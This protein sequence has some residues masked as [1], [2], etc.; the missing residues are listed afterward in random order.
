[1]S[2]IENRTENLSPNNVLLE[3]GGGVLEIIKKG[4]IRTT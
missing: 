4:I 1:M 2:E 3:P